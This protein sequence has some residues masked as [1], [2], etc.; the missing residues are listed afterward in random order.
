VGR[1]RKP[2]RPDVLVDF[3]LKTELK[4]LSE[5]MR[6]YEAGEQAKQSVAKP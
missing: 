2:D 3:T 4:E 1:H 5:Q 6:A